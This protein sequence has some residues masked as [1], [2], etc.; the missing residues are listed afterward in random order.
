MSVPSPPLGPSSLH[1][2]SVF[3]QKPLSLGSGWPMAPPI[4]ALGQDHVR[5]ALSFAS[6]PVE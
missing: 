6:G 2:A 1:T 3:P 4:I 5:I